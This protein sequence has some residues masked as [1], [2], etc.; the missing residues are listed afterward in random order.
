MPLIV[1]PFEPDDVPQVA[2]LR[3]RVFEHGRRTGPGELERYFHEIFFES[4]WRDPE[5]PSWVADDGG[6]IVG[7]IG[8]IPRPLASR[9]QALRGAVA[10]QIMVAPERRGIAGVQ[11]LK[12]VF[13][14]AQD[15]LYTDVA[16]VGARRLWERVGG[17]T[18]A[19]YSF[20]WTRPL[21]PARHAA[22][23]LGSAP[24]ARGARLFA[25]P[26]FGV[27]DSVATAAALRKPAACTAE[28]LDDLSVIAD[29]LPKLAPARA[30]HPSYDARSLAWL[31]ER[32]AERW[33]D[34]RV[35][36]V[37]VRAE[38]GAVA[39]WFVY[40]HAGEGTAQVLQIHAAPG[41][42][43]DVL[44]QLF[45]HAT[46]AGAMAVRGR[47]EPAFDDALRAA[48]CLWERQGQGMIVHA[49]DA[50]L[51]ATVLRGDALLSGLDGEWW[52]DF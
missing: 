11:I 52:L 34:H 10:S 37:L 17:S 33:S 15:V 48:G 24:A 39:G 18:A 2:A 21:R 8:V 46:R 5:L 23:R 41:R 50:A 51:L 27:I 44:R 31:F 9:G 42:H 12:R 6:Q 36:R 7:F 14:G 47:Y 19:L 43:A 30:I 49:R 29:T 3:R 32:A 1:R 16:N 13:A 40:L 26:L 28:P 35:E 20:A 22:S 45:R 4:P 25:G 38:D